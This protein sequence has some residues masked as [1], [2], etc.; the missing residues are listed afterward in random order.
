[1]FPLRQVPFSTNVTCNHTCA[2]KL[3]EDTYLGL[4]DS[5]LAQARPAYITY[6][7]SI[8]STPLA[9]LDQAADGSRLAAPMIYIPP[10]QAPLP[11]QAVASGLIYMQCTTSCPWFLR[12]Y[13]LGG[14]GGS[15]CL[16]RHAASERVES[17]RCTTPLPRLSRICSCSTPSLKCSGGCEACVRDC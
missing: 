13:A 5:T 4:A 7:P 9:D 1:M 2:Y 10:G 12:F 15:H 17:K 6:Y 14:T 3:T 11:V 16:F 8:A